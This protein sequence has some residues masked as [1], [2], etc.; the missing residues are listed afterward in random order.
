MYQH[1]LIILTETDELIGKKNINL[2]GMIKRI[3][4]LSSKLTDSDRIKT[5]QKSQ[6][7]MKNE[8][9]PN[10]TIF[11]QKIK[12]LRTLLEKHEGIKQNLIQRQIKLSS[13][14]EEEHK[15]LKFIYFLWNS[16]D[17]PSIETLYTDLQKKYPI[18]KYS[19]QAIEE[20]RGQKLLFS[21]IPVVSRIDHVKVDESFEWLRNFGNCIVVRVHDT[22]SSSYEDDSMNEIIGSSFLGSSV[23]LKTRFEYICDQSGYEL[24]PN[25]VLKEPSVIRDKII[26]YIELFLKNK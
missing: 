4:N 6:L 7:Q 24:Q 14:L 2:E 19:E 11:E 16:S 5:L 15:Y 26:A 12:K 8:D 22:S 3:E 13:L 21:F 20:E 17:L 25:Q 10:D 1:I 23:V 9:L 18:M